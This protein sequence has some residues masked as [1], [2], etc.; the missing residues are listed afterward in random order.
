ME[1]N[2]G[3]RFASGFFWG[4]IIGGG[5]VLFFKTEKGK[6]LLSKLS[7]EGLEQLASLTNIEEDI[8]EVPSPPKSGK[9]KEENFTEQDVIPR[10]SIKVLHVHTGQID[11]EV[12]GVKPKKT[13]QKEPENKSINRKLFKGISKG[14]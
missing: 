12:S 9:N 11:T 14:K 5:L 10:E 1:R 2:N 7:E 13:D 3:S 6:E 8:E 4:L